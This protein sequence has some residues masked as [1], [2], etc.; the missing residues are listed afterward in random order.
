MA[1]EALKFPKRKR[2]ETDK[3]S[4]WKGVSE[5]TSII[6]TEK[7]GKLKIAISWNEDGDDDKKDFLR[8]CHMD[9]LLAAE[10]LDSIEFTR[11]DGGERKSVF[12]V[13]LLKIIPKLRALTNVSKV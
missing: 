6:Q 5:N 13:T 9:E 8:A 11:S 3:E 10:S 2:E 12:D 1:E 4:N 7:L